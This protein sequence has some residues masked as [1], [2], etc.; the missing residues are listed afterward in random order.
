MLTLDP[1]LAPSLPFQLRDNLLD[2]LV[3]LQWVRPVLPHDDLR[4][5]LCKSLLKLL[6]RPEFFDL[7]ID[8]GAEL[9]S[10]WVLEDHGRELPLALQVVVV[11]FVHHD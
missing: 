5:L 8:Y 2:S 1:L 3:L 10:L 4:R 7:C 9:F 6:Q 11:L